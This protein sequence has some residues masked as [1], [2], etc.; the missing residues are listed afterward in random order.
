M[1]EFVNNLI[2]LLVVIPMGA[3]ILTIALRGHVLLQRV[4]GCTALITSLGTALYFVFSLQGGDGVL[5]SNLGNWPAPYGITVVLDG[6]SGA[7]LVVTQL[8][9]LAC[10]MHAF[11]V[12]NPRH[13]RGWFHPLFHLLIMGVNFSFLTG[14]LFNL[15]VAFEIML[16]A[17]YA[18]LCL[19]STQKQVTHAYKYVILNLVGSTLFVLGAGLVYG[20]LGT[21]NYADLA[22]IMAEVRAGERV[23]PPA[24]QIVS[25]MLLLVFG[26]KAAIFPLWFWLPDTYHT[27]PTSI[28][29]L[30][31]ALLSKV[32]VYAILRLYPSIFAAPGV[33]D[34][35]FVPIIAVAAGATMII[36]ILGA[37]G[38]SEIRRLL[39][40][41]LISHV[42]F[43]IFGIVLMS[44]RGHAGTLFYMVQ[45]MLVISALFLCCGMIEKHT[46][47]DKLDEIGGLL[48]RAPWL[49]VLFFVGL[50]ALVGIPPLSG[51]QGKVMMIWAGFEAGQWVLTGALVLAAVLTL[52]AALRVWSR[53]FWSPEQSLHSSLRQGA[54]VGSKP[55]L[56]W[57]FAGAIL[58][59][60][61]SV[62]IGLAAEPVIQFTSAATESLTTPKG[63]VTAVLGPD[64]WPEGG[65]IHAEAE[66]TGESVE[67]VALR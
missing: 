43:L 61:S 56:G 33:G 27:M 54:L 22:R 31:A 45:E 40:L 32:G 42:G 6:I 11:S 26:L 53:S 62:G 57:A 66:G 5:L 4:V 34:Q 17:S 10:Y 47:S 8:V 36:A 14:D 13:E 39:S 20:M 24:F 23:L 19:G 2:V 18:L 1:P 55:R 41:V 38:S 60:G 28:T 35:F 9:A 48:K 65:V 58:L 52:V 12:L 49:A 25:I 37:V 44:P 7:L 46:G 64:A 3:S 29:A 59:I 30:F 67:E 63:Y 51:F 15:F 50:M 21:L 16:L